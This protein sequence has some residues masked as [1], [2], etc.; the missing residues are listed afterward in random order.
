M[1]FY[2][3]AAVLFGLVRFDS[4]LCTLFVPLVQVATEMP[5][6]TGSNIIISHFVERLTTIPTKQTQLK[7][8]ASN[9]KIRNSLTLSLSIS[10]SFTRSLSFLIPSTAFFSAHI[11]QY[12]MSP[13]RMSHNGEPFRQRPYKCF[14]C[15]FNSTYFRL[16]SQFT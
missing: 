5:K 7:C 4:I 13:A 15:H 9:S 6:I 1:P 11:L 10:Y 3:A 12:I 8:N 2:C 14:L 16:S